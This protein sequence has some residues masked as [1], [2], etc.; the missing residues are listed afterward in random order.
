MPRCR[1]TRRGRKDVRIARAPVDNVKY[2]I[3]FTGGSTATPNNWEPMRQIGAAGCRDVHRRGCPAVG[4]FSGRVHNRKW[5]GYS[6]EPQS[7]AHWVWCA[8]A[9]KA[10][11]MPVPDF[12]SLKTNLNDPRTTNRIGTTTRDSDLKE[13]VSGKPI[14]GIDVV[15]G[16]C[17]RLREVPGLRWQSCLCQRRRSEKLK[18]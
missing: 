17:T 15:P 16:M 11:T 13:M 18:V 8:L 10:A 14:F 3:Q 7:A 6:R 9:A 1:R 2:G 4:M 5:Q 12:K